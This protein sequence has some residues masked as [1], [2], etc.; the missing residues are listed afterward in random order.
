[1][2]TTKGKFALKME[3]GA[4]VRNIDDLKAHFDIGSV[5]RYFSNGKL[6]TWLEDRYYDEEADAIRKISRTDKDL[7]QKLCAI[8]GIESAWIIERRNRLKKYT[9]DANILAN[10]DKVA[11]DQE[12]LADLLD[13]GA[14]EIYLCA[15]RFV[16]PLRMKNKT[17]IGVSGAVAVIRS[18]N[19]VNFDELGIKF[20]NIAFD[21]DYQRILP[22]VQRVT[23]KTQNSYGKRNIVVRAPLKGKLIQLNECNDPVFASGAMGRGVAIKNPE[24]KVFAPFD[25]EITVFFPTGHAIGL[26]SDDGIEML[27]HVGIDTVKMNGN[28]FTP[29]AEAGDRIRCG[30]ILLEFNPNVIKRAG[31]ETTTPVVITN[32]DDFGDITF[33]TDCQEIKANK[34]ISHSFSAQNNSFNSLPDD[35]RVANLIMQYVGGSNNIRTIEHC[36]TRLKLIVND[37]SKVQERD[38]ENIDGV[39]GQFF[40]AGFYQIILGT[41]FVEDVS[42]ELLKLMLS[43]K[44]NN[45]NTNSIDT[46][47]VNTNGVSILDL[48]KNFLRS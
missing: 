12:D 20:E 14:R 10:A 27:I 38:V 11:F 4:E 13:A 1:M 5:V 40:A 45:V 19:L 46:N 48:V 16:I 22:K 29:K 26:K 21:D 31:Y 44:N 6:L 36:A 15:N 35:K 17:Y 33:E 3:D 39:K 8:F 41:N 30:Q 25:G 24:G 32:H 18:K 7:N 37:K 47:D 9:N 2:Q 34:T 43:A 42:D 28:G 23:S